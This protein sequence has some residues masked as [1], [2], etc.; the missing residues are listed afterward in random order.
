MKAVYKQRGFN[1]LSPD[2]LFCQAKSGIPVSPQ[3]LLPREGTISALPYA[4]C[5]SVLRKG[6]SDPSAYFLLKRNVGLTRV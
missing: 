3:P 6:V 1:E 5:S 2:L 4:D